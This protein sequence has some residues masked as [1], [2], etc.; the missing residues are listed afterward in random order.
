MDYHHHHLVSHH[1]TMVVE[2]AS[3]R[4]GGCRHDV[5]ESGHDVGNPYNTCWINPHSTDRY[6]RSSLLMNIIVIL[7]ALQYTPHIVPAETAL[8]HVQPSHAR[9]KLWLS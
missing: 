8:H 1:R 6:C 3:R 9:E 4:L 7:H 5:S 2:A